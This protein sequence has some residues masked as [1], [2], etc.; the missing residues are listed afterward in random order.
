MA[1][2]CSFMNPKLQRER[3][4]DR[5]EQVQIAKCADQREEDLL[6]RHPGQHT[7]E[8]R[9]GDDRGEHQQHR[10]RADI[11][12]QNRVERNRG[13]VAGQD[14]YPAHLGVGISVTQ[15][16]IPGVGGSGCLQADQHDRADHV[17]KRDFRERVPD[18][19]EPARYVPAGKR[20][21]GA[22]HDDDQ[23]ADQDP[24]RVQPSLPGDMLLLSRHPRDLRGSSADHEIERQP[25]CE[26]LAHDLC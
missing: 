6:H 19:F 8:R 14:L 16:R 3:P 4:A 2:G 24:P 11:R 1:Q 15:D 10:Q 22:D 25:L 18:V 17:A 23:Y 13:R 7:G 5:Q 12:R 9:G 21:G 20:R 26:D